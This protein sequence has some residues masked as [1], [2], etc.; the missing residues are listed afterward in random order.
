[1]KG[2]SMSGAGILDGDLVAVRMQPEVAQ[3]EIGVVIVN[4]EATVK[5]VYVRGRKVRLVS[6][7]ARLAER[8]HEEPAYEPMEF[9]AATDDLRIAGK[10]IGVLR[11]L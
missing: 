8:Q 10:A 3:G 11:R 1:V 2:D 7:P 4:D 9:D 6:A 5:R